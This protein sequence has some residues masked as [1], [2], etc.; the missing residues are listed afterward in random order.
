MPTV[1][2]VIPA[3][4]A[5]RTILETIASVQNQT[6][7]DF[8]II[9]INDGSK[10]RTL[11][12]IQSVSDEKI[13]IISCENS[14]VC[15]ARNRG[16]SHACGEFV[17]FIDADDLWTPEK[18]ED[19]LNA[20]R[21][22]TD[23]DVAYSWTYFFY[24]QTGDKKPGE[25]TFYEGNILPFLLKNNFIASGSNILLRKDAISQI[26]NFDPT[27][28]HCADW[29]FYLRLAAQC[30]YV[31]V[32]KHQIIY[33]QSTTSMTSTKLED[34]ERQLLL[35]LD[36]TY[37]FIPD[38]LKNL[39][40]HSLSWVYQYCAQ[41]YLQYNT[42]LAGVRTASQK[43]AKALQIRPQ[44]LLEDYGQSLVRWLV[45]RWLSSLV[46]FRKGFGF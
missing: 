21:N 2:V 14:G 42:N 28:P 24:E 3:Y 18:L 34:I 33:R 35:M 9:I 19:Q 23:A 5:E 1:S 46:S 30:N 44:I 36:K 12:I 17:S 15:E 11:E 8:E 29:D 6:F 16:I 25:P 26:G 40:R 10:D 32:P 27:F 37:K 4:N 31:L 38:D 7:S 43:F 13:K 22:K 20:L 41:Q 39:K 45:K